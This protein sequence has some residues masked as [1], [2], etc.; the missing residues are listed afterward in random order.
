MFRTSKMLEVSGSS[1]RAWCEKREICAEGACRLDNLGVH[2]DEFE[3]TADEAEHSLC[4][5]SQRFRPTDLHKVHPT[6]ECCM[7][8]LNF[9]EFPLGRSKPDQQAHS[10]EAFVHRRASA[11]FQ[12]HPIAIH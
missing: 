4:L 9:Q 1:H 3:T 6:P 8:D 11:L 7:V 2:G 12:S 10:S 5:F